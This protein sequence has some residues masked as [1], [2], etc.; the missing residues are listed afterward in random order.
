[1]MIPSWYHA[2]FGT[3]FPRVQSSFRSSRLGFR[4][5]IAL[6]AEWMPMPC[7]FAEVSPTRTGDS[8]GFPQ[9]S[10]ADA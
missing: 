3:W 1:M 4:T 10:V 6:S 8:M 5:G 2:P 9:P 7:F